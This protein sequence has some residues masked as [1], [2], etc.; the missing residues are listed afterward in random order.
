MYVVIEDMHKVGV[1]K[2]GEN[3]QKIG[4]DANS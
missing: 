4:K 3:T 1:R 2:K